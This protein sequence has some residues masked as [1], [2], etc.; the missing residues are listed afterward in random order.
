MEGMQPLK[1]DT[2]PKFPGMMRGGARKVTD[3]EGPISLT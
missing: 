3:E 1:L 2:Q